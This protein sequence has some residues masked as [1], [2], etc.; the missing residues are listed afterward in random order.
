MSIGWNRIHRFAYQLGRAIG[1]IWRL[2]TQRGIEPDAEQAILREIVVVL[3]KYERAVRRR[4]R[5]SF[6]PPSNN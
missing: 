6:T 4:S 5:R 1:H 3:E 2:K